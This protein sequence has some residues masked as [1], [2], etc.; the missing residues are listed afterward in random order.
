MNSLINSINHAEI[1]Y[2]L[3]FNKKK[4][5]F[6]LPTMDVTFPSLNRGNR[7]TLSKHYLDLND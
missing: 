6:D 2:I 3:I 1:I 4:Y 5:A 7:L